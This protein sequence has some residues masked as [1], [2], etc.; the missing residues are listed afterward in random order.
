MDFKLGH[1]LGFRGIVPFI[2]AFIV[3][4]PVDL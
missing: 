1:Y 2:D 4:C 3:S